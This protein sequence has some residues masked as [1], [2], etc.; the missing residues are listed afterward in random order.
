MASPTACQSELHVQVCRPELV[1]KAHVVFGFGFAGRWKEEFS[2]LHRIY[3]KVSFDLSPAGGQLL[4]IT[5][6]V[7]RTQRLERCQTEMSRGH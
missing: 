5:R 1:A 7:C 6:F 4:G 2:A 3:F